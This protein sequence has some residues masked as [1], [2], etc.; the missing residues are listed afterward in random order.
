VTPASRSRLATALW[1][2]GVVVFVASSVLGVVDH[3]GYNWTLASQ[4]V[5][6]VSIGV[7]GWILARRRPENP[8]GW[9]YLGVWLGVAV[10]FGFL[11]EYATW[12]FNHDAP[13]VDLATWMTNWAWVPIFGALL[14]F[15]FLLFPDGRLLSRRWR[16]VVW[17]LGVVL[18]LWS[19]SFAFETQ[20]YVDA[21]DRHVLNPFTP[22]G[23]GPFFNVAKQVLA[24]A[25]LA[26][27]AI[28]LASLFIRFRRATGDERQQVKWLLYSGTLLVAWLIVPVE[29]GNETWV[30]QIQGLLIALIPISIGIAV[31]KYRLYEI[32]VVIRKTVV[33]ALLTAF[34]ALV[35]AAIVGGIGALVGEASNTTLAFVAAAVLAVAF[36]PARDAARRFADRLVYG[37]RATPYEVLSAFSGRM[38]ETYATEDVLPRMAQILGEGT[39]AAAAT[40]W[41]RVGGVLRPAGSWPQERRLAPITIAGDALPDLGEPAVAVVD[42]GD[43][44]GAL[45]TTFP[46]SDPMSPA[47]ERLVH[48]LASQAGLVLRNVRLIE[49]LRA[50]RQRLVAAQDDER[51]KLERDLHDGAQQQ[52][53]ALQVQLRLATQVTQRDPAKGAPMI[54]ALQG[55]AAAALEDLRDLARG[56]YPPLLADQGL[57]A[58]LESQARKASLSVQ[59]EPD[60]VGRYDRGVESAV[61]FCALEA[62]NNVAKYAKA[63][64]ATV[65]LAQ[66]NGVL[67]FE[68]ID[69]GA[70][71]DAGATSYG[72]GLQGMADRLDAVGGTLEVRSAPGGG[73]TV[74]GRVP[75][76]AA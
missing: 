27:F 73:T 39:G 71:F 2:F 43:L 46:P 7:V 61:Y 53:V 29:H 1:L 34:I 67:R 3:H 32:D 44:L 52:L 40:V 12:A 48:D 30:D 37:R 41:L 33:V 13:F 18:A 11:E 69:D 20:D 42:A 8:I 15:P 5:A 60:G 56:I 68:V 10:V 23:L 6:F 63:S 21:A 35:Y 14:S 26:L 74:I 17:T 50:S 24:V 55:Q 16:P 62:L 49:E 75:V 45:S 38:R 31:L 19:M 4:V 9:I 59:V 22:D 51:R 65:R 72:T 64:T 57:A 28:S 54:R 25:S 66:S 58:A 70:G 36:Q 47:K 76:S